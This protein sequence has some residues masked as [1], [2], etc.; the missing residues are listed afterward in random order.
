VLAEAD[1]K[2]KTKDKT[3]SILDKLLIFIFFTPLKLFKKSIGYIKII[4]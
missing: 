4:L 2:P 3:I 1:E